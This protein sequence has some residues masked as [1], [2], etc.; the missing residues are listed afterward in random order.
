[1]TT[2]QLKIA[3]AAAVVAGIGTILVFQHPAQ[4]EERELNQAS[5]Q[6]VGQS[7]READER[8]SSPATVE[9][10]MPTEPTE[11]E[12]IQETQERNNQL[13]VWGLDFHIYASKHHDRFPESW[14]QALSMS[15][16]RARLQDPAELAP[17]LEFLTNNFEIVYRGTQQ[18]ISD[19]GKTI[20]F[21]EKQAR[22]SP[23]GEWV[24]VYGFADGSAHIH[25]EASEANFA[26]WE[27]AR[28]VAAR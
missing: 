21:Q 24:K 19:P 15:Q 11:A 27:R 8:P 4:P 28:T 25:T 1:L 3:V 20:L 18:G 9:P 17:Y 16:Q 12:F 14:E 10:T 7:T 6:S 26:A 22:R 23:Q 2:T 5:P 13:K